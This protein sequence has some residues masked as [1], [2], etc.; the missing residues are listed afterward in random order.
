MDRSSAH[1]API[2]RTVY[3]AYR[4]A[5]PLVL[6]VRVSET[7]RGFK[8][9]VRIDTYVLTPD[10]GPVCSINFLAPCGTR[11]SAHALP[12]SRRFLPEILGL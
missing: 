3:T 2:L 12:T 7:R 5:D 4:K 6:P 1:Y 8:K 11:G 9:F 10:S